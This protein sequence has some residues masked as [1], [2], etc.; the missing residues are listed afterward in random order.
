MARPTSLGTLVRLSGLFLG[1]LAYRVSS[2]QLHRRL[3]HLGETIPFKQGFRWS[4]MDRTEW[5]DAV[6]PWLRLL[7][8][9]RRWH[10][11]TLSCHDATVPLPTPPT[12]SAMERNR[13]R[14]TPNSILSLCSIQ[15]GA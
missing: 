2:H 12:L 1:D 15:F 13:H 14:A 4:T 9:S 11:G 7:P 8:Y 6:N 5:S 10:R 3:D